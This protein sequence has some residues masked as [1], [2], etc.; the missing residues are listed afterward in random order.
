MAA[1]AFFGLSSAE[2]FE[3]PSADTSTRVT[4]AESRTAALPFTPWPRQLLTAAWAASRA[5]AIS[6]PRAGGGCWPGCWAKTVLVV[7]AS[8]SVPNIVS[9]RIMGDSSEFVLGAGRNCRSAEGYLLAERSASARMAACFGGILPSLKQ[10]RGSF[11]SIEN[12][13]SVVVN[14]FRNSQ[15]AR[16]RVARTPEPG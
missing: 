16:R 9:D 3:E 11:Q 7:A 5:S 12:P 10:E 13:D 14:A 1:T 6:T 15:E 4:P 8:A 2:F